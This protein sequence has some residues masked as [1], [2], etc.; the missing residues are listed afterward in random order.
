MLLYN[1]MLD[2]KLT[3]AQN[4]DDRVIVGCCRSTGSIKHQVETPLMKPSILWNR[5]SKYCCWLRSAFVASKN[6]VVEKAHHDSLISSS[7]QPCRRRR[8]TRFRY[9]SPARTIASRAATRGGTGPVRVSSQYIIGRLTNGKP[10]LNS[11]SPR[12]L[13]SCVSL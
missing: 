4:V 8:P 10:G 7:F 5:G 13:S 12:L 6:D 2:C 11:S 9:S 1:F 3:V